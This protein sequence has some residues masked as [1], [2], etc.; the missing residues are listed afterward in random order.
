[1]INYSLWGVVAHKIN[2]LC[3]DLAPHVHVVTHIDRTANTTTSCPNKLKS[4]K[5]H[6]SESVIPTRNLYA[7]LW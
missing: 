5:M 1:M 7:F 2:S 4:V 6:S 3:P